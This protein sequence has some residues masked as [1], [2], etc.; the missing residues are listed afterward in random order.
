MAQNT[1]LKAFM[2][3]QDINMYLKN[4]TFCPEDLSFHI[5]M[6]PR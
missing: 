2:L 3:E 4:Y 5:A 6:W 1:T